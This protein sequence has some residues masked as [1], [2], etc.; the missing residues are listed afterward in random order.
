MPVL[1][2]EVGVSAPFRTQ[3]AYTGRVIGLAKGHY[4][5]T[6]HLV[7]GADTTLTFTEPVDI[8]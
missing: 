1:L 6:F 7:S 8:R 3:H 5:L 4:D 2:Q